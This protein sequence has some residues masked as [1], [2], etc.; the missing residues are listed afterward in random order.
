MNIVLPDELTESKFTLIA[1][2]IYTSISKNKNE[3]QELTN[4][5]DTLLTKLISGELEINEINN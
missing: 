1:N 2:D 4:L 5:R 3:N